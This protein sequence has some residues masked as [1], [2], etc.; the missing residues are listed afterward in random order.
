MKP[1][2]VFSAEDQMVA[3]GLIFDH[4]GPLLSDKCTAP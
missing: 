4:L 3:F 2:V 1:R